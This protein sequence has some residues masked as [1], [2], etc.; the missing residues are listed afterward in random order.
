MCILT[1]MI[2]TIERNYEL[3]QNITYVFSCQVIFNLR[4]IFEKFGSFGSVDR[5][6]VQT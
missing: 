6:N 4:E 3:T 2:N 5:V 1:K